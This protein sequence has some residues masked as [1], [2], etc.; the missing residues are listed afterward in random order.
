M[1]EERL[2]LFV[3]LYWELCVL[4]LWMDVEWIGKFRSVVGRCYSA[5]SALDCVRNY[6]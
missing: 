5:T 4:D 1:R 6:W 2:G 3:E